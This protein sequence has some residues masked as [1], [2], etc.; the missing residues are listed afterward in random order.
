MVV[1]VVLR[2]DD[3][4]REERLLQNQHGRIRDLRFGPDGWLYML[5]DEADG[6]LIRVTQ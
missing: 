3:V 5:T 1:H 6:K 2:G 4:V